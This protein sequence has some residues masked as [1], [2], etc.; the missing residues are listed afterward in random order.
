[1]KRHWCKN[2]KY[3]G[4]MWCCTHWAVLEGD[5]RRDCRVECPGCELRWY[6]RLRTRI[7]NWLKGLKR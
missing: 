6:I 4:G 3:I 2:T 7:L 1:M 5:L